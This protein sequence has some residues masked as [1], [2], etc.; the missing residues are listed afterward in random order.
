MSQAKAGE[1]TLILRGGREH[2][3]LLK[4]QQETW[5]PLALPW[6]FRESLELHKGS[7]ACFQGVRRNSRLLSRRFRGN[8]PHLAL[9]GGGVL[10]F[11]LSCGGKLWVPL[12]FRQGPQRT[13]HVATVESGLLLSCRSHLVIPFKLLQGNKAS[14]RVEA[15]NLGFLSSCDRDLRLLLKL[16]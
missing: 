7:Q 13:S 15:G 10:W 5:G 1:L 3:A 4:I 16:Q 6:L 9:R 8:R 2:G 11:F 14:F 12:E